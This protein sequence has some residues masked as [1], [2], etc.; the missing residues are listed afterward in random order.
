MTLHSDIG[1]EILQRA[2]R[3]VPSVVDSLSHDEPDFPVY[4]IPCKGQVQNG[5]I[6]VSARQLARAVDRTA[7]WLQGLIGRSEA[8]ETVSY[9]GPQDIRYCIVLL[10]A[11]KT[12]R[13]VRP[14]PSCQKMASLLRL[15]WR[16]RA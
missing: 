13:K 9:L 11:A 7:W 15:A 14:V 5:Y 2:R 4:S 12:G 1:F 3:L 8:F 6:D 16:I 10:A